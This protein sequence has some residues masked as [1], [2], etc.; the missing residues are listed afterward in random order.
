[1]KIYF[2]PYAYLR[3]RQL[4]TI[5]RWP[6][7]EVVNPEVSD[8]RRGG[9]VSAAYANASTLRKSWKSRLPLIN[10]KFRPRKAPKDAVIYVWGAV[11]ATGSFIVD[12]DNPWSLT[13]YN[14]RA[15]SLYQPI[16]RYILASSRCREIRCISETCRLSLK[17]LFGQAVYDKARV[18]YPCIPQE[19]SCVDSAIP[20]SCRFLFVGTQFEIK[21]GEALLKAFRRVYERAPS[22]RLDVITHLPAKYSDL[23]KSC[24]GIHVHEARFSRDEIHA[25]FMNQADVLVL[26]TYAESFGMVALEGLA[27]GLALIATDVYALREMVED[28]KNGYLIKPPISIWDGIMPSRYFYELEHI[29]EHIEKTET[30]VFE[31]KLE[32]AMY[33]FA[34]NPEFRLAARQA[35]V[36]IMKERFTC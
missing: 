4:D 17:A 22:A 7:G 2:Y 3:D 29:K 16:L 21:G 23:A 25:Q 1:M 13:G 28:G 32:R 33:E 26:P 6:S 8:K 18:H 11:V 12:L 20:D 10:V 31:E 15:M 36:R 19:V 35:S 14:L 27:H 5:R 9:Q 24:A 30:T 34:I